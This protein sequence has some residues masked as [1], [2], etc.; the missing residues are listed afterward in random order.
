MTNFPGARLKVDRAYTHIDELQALSDWYCVPDLHLPSFESNTATGAG[1]IFLQ[2]EPIPPQTAL[3]IGD[4]IHCLRAALDHAAFDL[5]KGKAQK[6]FI[7]FPFGKSLE[8]L[9]ATIKG[10][11]IQVAGPAVI[12]AI[13][14]EIRPYLIDEDT[15]E[16]GNAPLW[17]LNKLDNIDKHR[18]V[19]LALSKVHTKI[20]S[21][22]F[23]NPSIIVQ[24]VTII[25]PGGYQGAV[26]GI[27]GSITNGHG[28]TSVEIVFDEPEFF[29]GE[30]VIPTLHQLAE[31]TASA[32]DILEPFG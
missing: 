12:D 8:S 28:T 2:S 7:S 22:R 11:Q 1:Q 24:D 30:P 17:K 5:T 20:E 9:K 32:L 14:D 4:A 10:G 15:G 31:L 13:I 3:I 29:S 19:L 16:H 25:T 21:L 26:M 18:E 23:T 27:S 6:E